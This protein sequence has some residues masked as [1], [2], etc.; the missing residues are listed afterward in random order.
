MS[1]ELKQ[2]VRR[3][4]ARSDRVLAESR[5][6]RALIRETLERSRALDRRSGSISGRFVRRAG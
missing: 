2:Q 3:A 5:R 6:E 4:I 1:S